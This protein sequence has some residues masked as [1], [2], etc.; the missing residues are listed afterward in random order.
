M[1]AGSRSADAAEFE[2]PG[3][4][5]SI[6][7]LIADLQR[8]QDVSSEAVTHA[9][10]A[11]SDSEELFQ[12]PSCSRFVSAEATSC[13]CGV[14]FATTP[15]VSSACP[16]CGSLVP[17]LEDACPVCGIELEPGQEEV[18]YTCPRCGSHVALDAIQCLCGVWFED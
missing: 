3:R 11:E 4:H 18:A 10:E 9:P 8:V 12:C 1:H 5:R 14:R 6:S 17:V 15:T 13:E 2:A 7:E 16:E